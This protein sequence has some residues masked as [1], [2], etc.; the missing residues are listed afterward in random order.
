MRDGLR[1]IPVEQ[2]EQDEVKYIE[3]LLDGQSAASG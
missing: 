2:W 3:G 1:E